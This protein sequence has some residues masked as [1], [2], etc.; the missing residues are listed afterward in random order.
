M[1]DSF[2]PTNIINIFQMR[3]S[4]LLAY[5]HIYKLN[6]FKT[7]CM[8]LWTMSDTKQVLNKAITYNS[9]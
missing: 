4:T 2:T 3:H 7:I 1:V 8:I 9:P 5:L 6:F